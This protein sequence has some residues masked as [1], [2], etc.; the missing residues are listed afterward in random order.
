MET[1][2]IKAAQLIVSLSI[3][4]IV[5]EFGHFLFSRLFK[6]RVE[7]FYIFFNPQISLIRW[8]KILGKWQIRLFSPN[9]PPNTR[10]K[11]DASGKEIKNE[12][13][14]PEL[15][16]IPQSDFEES[17]WRKYPDNTEWGV[18]WLPLGG[19]CKISGMIDESMDTVALKAEPQPWEFR[20]KPAW[21][22][23]LIMV[24]GVLMN[25]ILAFVIYS[26]IAF[27]W[28]DNYIRMDKTPLTFGQVARE[29]GFQ[30]GDILLKADGKRL[31]RYD[32]LDIFN[33]IKA[34]EVTVLRN[35]IE[36]NINLPEDFKLKI[37]SS[38]APFA[39]YRT[40]KIDS[41]IPKSAAE[42]AGLI[43]GDRIVALNSNE[44]RSFSD[45]SLA[46]ANNKN[47]TVQLTV[48]RDTA[49]IILSSQVSEDGKLG[50][51][52]V[53]NVVFAADKHTI[54]SAIP[55]GIQ[56]GIRKLTFYVLQLRIVFTK[57]G[58]ANIGGFGAIGNLFP[59]KW[60]WP[61]FW[62]MTAFLSIMLGV[63]NLLPIPA[64]DGGHVLFL[65]VEVITRRRPSDKF[66]EYA[67]YVGMI[68]LLALLLYANG[69]DV[70][71]LF[72]K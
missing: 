3:L 15:E 1:I 24:G 29:A 10:P 34:S 26:F 35:N 44:V 51:Y 11:T 30:D 55:A 71:R 62:D 61:D 8:K 13:G 12:K 18:G 69:N 17:D 48:E 65:L 16:L 27:Q 19:Y 66:L 28:G 2:L 60:S 5:H 31:S 43:K 7:K 63:M 32:E 59:P 21:Q 23:L 45:L 72:Q 22:R 52:P 49:I 70:L 58:M 40:A 53:N 36:E 39:D 4:V 46:L 64:L 67:Q 56:L 38:K 20:S 50:F 47:T 9:V 14:K 68:L 54:F 41:V 33:V 37:I 57:E 25:F 6:V 42:N